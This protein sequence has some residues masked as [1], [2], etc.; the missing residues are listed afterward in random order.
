MILPGSSGMARACVVGLDGMPHSL[1]SRL[2]GEGVM[3]AVAELISTGRLYRMRVSIPDISAVSWTSFATGANPGVHGIFGFVDLKPDSYGIRFPNYLD[4]TARAIW[5]KVGAAGGTSVVINQPFT[6]PVR[7]L[8]GSMVAGFVALDLERG[9]YPPELAG[10]LSETGYKIDIDVSRC[11]ANHNLIWGELAETLESRRRALAMLWDTGWNYLQVV[12]T[13]TDRLHHYLWDAV[14]NRDHPHHRAAMAYYGNV[15]QFVGEVWE[16]FRR[17][18]GETALERFFLLSDHGF[19]AV[20]QEV[21]LN[22]WLMDQGYLVLP[23]DAGDR[24]ALEAIDERTKAFCLDP[25]RIYINLKGRF[26]RGSVK[27]HEAPKLAQE[28]RD[29]LSALQYGGKPVMRKVFLGS[30]L[31]SGPQAS[32]GPDVV[33]LSHPGFDLKGSPGP[34]S[35]FG[36]SDLKGMH[37]WDDAF[38]LTGAE[39]NPPLFIWDLSAKI[40]EKLG[41]HKR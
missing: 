27:S 16:R 5:D 37:T 13:G 2:A 29:R 33:A 31:Y 7:P 3:P 32:K 39:L 35:L 22:R 17:L 6:Y 18:D 34:E 36:R 8:R 15:D 10:K 20:E 38:V 26:P 4:C 1:I 11:R 28:I 23:G 9:T 41:V 24:S 21:Y 30:E 19:C 12:V 25:G 40:L 14:E